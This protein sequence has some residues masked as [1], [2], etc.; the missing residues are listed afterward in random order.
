MFIYSDNIRFIRIKDVAAEVKGVGAGKL[1]SFQHEG[2][3]FRFINFSHSLSHTH[4][5]IV[6]D[7]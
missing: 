1:L 4:T 7:T 2:Y 5:C 6:T 3:Y